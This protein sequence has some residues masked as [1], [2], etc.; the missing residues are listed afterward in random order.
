MVFIEAYYDS[1]YMR[2]P[3]GTVGQIR[4]P[5]NRE[6]TDIDRGSIVFF[7]V[8]VVDESEQVGKILAE[9]DGIVP[10]NME[11]VSAKRLCLLPVVFKDLGPAV[12]R[13]QY[14]SRPVLEVNNRIP[15]VGD[16]IKDIVR[17]DRAFFALVWPA[18]LR[19][20]LTKILIIDEHDPLDVDLGNWRVQWLVFVRLFYAHQ[21]PQFFSDDPSTREEQ[22]RWIDEAVRAFCSVHGVAEKYGSTR[23]EVLA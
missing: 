23:Q 11:S 16:A 3:F 7:R 18:V 2:F 8:K 13:L 9:A 5:S 17:T 1:S 14:D 6:L 19:E 15:G 10:H 4:P 12:W 22:L 21:A 20:L